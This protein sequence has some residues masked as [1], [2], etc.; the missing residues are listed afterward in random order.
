MKPT[1]ILALLFIAGCG[2]EKTGSSPTVIRGSVRYEGQN[3]GTLEVSLFT[4]FPPRGRPIAVRRIEDPTFPVDYEFGHLPPG[5]YFVLAMIDRDDDDGAR[6]HPTLDP[7]G[8][9]GGFTSPAA[10][11]LRTG[12]ATEGVD[13]ELVDPSLSSPWIRRNYR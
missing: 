10:V 3:Q 9:H 5:R 8:A 1:A 12:A 7:G 6:F 2:T 13:V 11:T 4:S